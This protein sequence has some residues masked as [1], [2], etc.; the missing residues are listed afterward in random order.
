MRR[1]QSGLRVR[2]RFSAFSLCGFLS[3]SAL[4]TAVAQ[5]ADPVTDVGAAAR[6]AERIQNDL[7]DQV[8]RQREQDLRSSEPPTHFEVQAPQR[9]ERPAGPCRPITEIDITGVTLLSNSVVEEI[10]QQWQGQCIGVAQ[11]EQI[12]G[13]LTVAYMDKGYVAARAY[14][15]AQDLTSGKLTIGV[16]EG[17]V[18]RIEVNDGGKNSIPLGNVAP[19]VVGEPLNLRDLEQALDQINRLASN[20]ATMQIAPGSTPGD[21]VVVFSNTPSRRAH[22]SLTYDNYGQKAT[23]KN[24]AGVNVS[25]DNPLGFNDFISFT[26]RR[27]MPYDTGRHSAYMDNISYVIPFGYSTLSFN[28][29]DSEYASILDAPSGAELET[30]GNSKNYAIQLDHVLWRGQQSQW[31][32]S[33]ALTKKKTENYLEGILL[34]VSSR[35]LTVFDLDTAFTTR[36]LG[37][38]LTLTGGVARG[39]TWFDALDD[40]S[41]LPSWAPR[42]QFTKV[43]YG[44]NFYRPFQVAGHNLAYTAQ[45]S[46]QHAY[47]VLYGSEQFSIG[48]PYTVRGFSEDSLNGDQGQYLRNDLSLSEPV[49][50]PGGYI[51]MLRP[52][53]ALD[54]GKVWNRVG[55]VPEGEL[56]SASIGVGLYLGPLTLDVLVAHPLDKPGFM[57]KQ[58]DSTFFNLGLA[59]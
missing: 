31:S 39:L 59:F 34:D 52:Y 5:A 51:A 35:S 13:A 26:H 42:A 43:K 20:D 33:G 18:E 10:E 46:G 25:L 38:A 48:S 58:G 54:W 21:S 57:E 49:M 24:Q 23:G 40:A 14:L 50:L 17:Q 37:G 29:S 2:G 47:D 7:R 4:A 11:I 55:D 15:P 56:S 8:Q 45:F 27:S 53:V 1:F 41:D 12:L 19:G 44:A 28:V 32:L 36:V 9:K 22:A 16:A 3:L 6:Q 30:N